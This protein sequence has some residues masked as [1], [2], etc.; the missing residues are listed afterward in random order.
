MYLECFSL[1][2]GFIVVVV[3]QQYI[4]LT[5]IGC[6]CCCCCYS[7]PKNSSF[8]PH[9]RPMPHASR[10]LLPSPFSP[11]PTPT[12]VFLLDFRKERERE[13]RLHLPT[14]LPTTTLQS[15]YLS[16]AGIHTEKE[17]K[18]EQ[19]GQTMRPVVYTQHTALA[20]RF[21]SQQQQ[22]QRQR[23][24]SDTAMQQR[25]TGVDVHHTVP[26]YCVPG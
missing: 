16:A 19:L 25:A 20:Y 17:R 8:T 4:S 15:L 9:I 18:R 6:C 2:H 3:S 21:T 12:H 23:R 10:H 5:E 11:T 14:Y 13:T 26:V 1:L 22:R 7:R 24:Y